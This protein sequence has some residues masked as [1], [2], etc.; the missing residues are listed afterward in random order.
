MSINITPVPYKSNANVISSADAKRADGTEKVKANDA[1]QVSRPQEGAPEEPFIKVT[2][3][4][5]RVDDLIALDSITADLQSDDGR[6][7]IRAMA[8]VKQLFGRFLVGPDG[9]YMVQAEAETYIGG[10]SIA[11][12]NDLMQEFVMQMEVVDQDIIPE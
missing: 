11:E 6:T 12:L 9:E 5:I 3:T 10:L 7:R 4:R 1:G 8:M 2:P